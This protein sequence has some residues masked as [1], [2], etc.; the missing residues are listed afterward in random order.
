MRWPCLL[1]IKPVFRRGESQQLLDRM[2]FSD[3]DDVSFDIVTYQLVGNI[4]DYQGFYGVGKLG[5][6]SGE[7][8]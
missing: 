3:F 7:K 6:D 8:A 4:E 5:F 1:E 2:K